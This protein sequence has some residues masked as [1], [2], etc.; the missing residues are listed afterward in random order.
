M[1]YQKNLLYQIV[2]FLNE[3]MGVRIGIIRKTE[4][5][6]PLH[7]STL[8]KPHIN[9]HQF[10]YSNLPLKSWPVAVRTSYRYTPVAC[11]DEVKV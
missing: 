5:G 6:I 8:S 10:T 2:K 3:R 9:Y 11:V 1:R 4:M 7:D